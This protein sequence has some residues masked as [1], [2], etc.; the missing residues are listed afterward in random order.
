MI[1]AVFKYMEEVIEVR[2]MSNSLWFRINGTTG[3]FAPIEGIQISKEGAMKENP[4]L[5]D[6]PRWRE[7]SIQRLKEKINSFNT[8]K[9]RMNYVIND[10]KKIGYIPLVMQQEGFRPVKLN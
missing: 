5:K 8:E 9:E 4:D 3:G 2:I 7:I 1:G 6:N 10:L